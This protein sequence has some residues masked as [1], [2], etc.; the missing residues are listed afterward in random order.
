[1]VFGLTSFIT[2]QYICALVFLIRLVVCLLIQN[3]GSPTKIYQ[4]HVPV[5]TSLF[6]NS[7]FSFQVFYVAAFPAMNGSRSGGHFWF[8]DYK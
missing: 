2:F 3:I 8:F 4:K 7:S 1:M 5:C 6:G